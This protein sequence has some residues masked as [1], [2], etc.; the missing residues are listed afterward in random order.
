[1]AV[2]HAQPGE[3]VDLQ[4]LGDRLRSSKTTA[5]V[6]TDSFEAIRLIL[7]AGT[8]LPAHQVSGA[9]TLHCLEG[10]VLVGLPG[11]HLELSGGQW[12]FLQG[13]TSHSVKEIEDASLL[14]TIL[15]GQ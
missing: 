14:L 9:I 7:Q 10:R 12:I 2:H 8:E 6:K 11:S 3:I 13:R 1:M 4:P 5:I 15:L